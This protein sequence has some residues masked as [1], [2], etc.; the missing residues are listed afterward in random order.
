MDSQVRAVHDQFPSADSA[1]VAILAALN[2]AKQY[3]LGK[4]K[5]EIEYMEMEALFSEPELRYVLMVQ[6]G[7]LR[8]PDQ[9]PPEP[10][11][12]TEEE[13]ERRREKEREPN[14]DRHKPHSRPPVA[15]SVSCAEGQKAR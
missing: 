13:R 8:Q 10:S 9:I 1:R 15:K 7:A 2:I 12:L 6:Q 5:Q 4:M 11:P 14:Q 3:H